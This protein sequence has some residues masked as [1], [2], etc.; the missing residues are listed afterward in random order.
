M[1]AQELVN[2]LTADNF[3]VN[4]G[5]LATAHSIFGRCVILIISLPFHSPQTS[6]PPEPPLA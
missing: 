6:L 2:S 1:I 5:V 4:N 3:V